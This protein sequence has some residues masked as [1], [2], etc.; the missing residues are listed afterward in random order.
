GIETCKTEK[1]DVKASGEDINEEDY[2]PFFSD[3]P[4][5]SDSTHQLLGGRP[6]SGNRG[7]RSWIDVV[8]GRETYKSNA[9][10]S[11]SWGS[12]MNNARSGME[13]KYISLSDNCSGII[14]IDGDMIDDEPWLF[15]AVGYFLRP[16]MAF[17]HVHATTRILWGCLGLVD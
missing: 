4:K 1:E 2:N 15:C 13:L 6:P 10:E 12:I 17:G 9:V 7:K 11:R 8:N 5:P 16:D 14:D 3:P